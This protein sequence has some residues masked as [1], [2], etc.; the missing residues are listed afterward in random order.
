MGKYIH[1]AKMG[2]GSLEIFYLWEHQGPS[3]RLHCVTPEG[4]PALPREPGT[5]SA[6]RSSSH[7]ADACLQLAAKT[8]F[9]TKPV[10]LAS[11]QLVNLGMKWEHWF[12]WGSQQKVRP[13]CPRECGF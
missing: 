11:K 8:G 9:T 1:K 13:R 10:W 6:P 12:L 3:S 2:K 7:T 4:V 5:C